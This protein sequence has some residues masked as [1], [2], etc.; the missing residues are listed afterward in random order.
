MP[1]MIGRNSPNSYRIESIVISNNEGNSYDVSNIFETF[2]ITE[3]IYQ[4]FLTGSITILD[5]TNLFNRI[6]ITGQ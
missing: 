6:G 2:T 5:G 1:I 3:S 4:M